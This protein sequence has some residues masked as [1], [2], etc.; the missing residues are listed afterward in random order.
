MGQIIGSAAKPKRCN[1]NKLSQFGTPAAGEHI[2]VSSDNSMNAAGQGNFDCYIVGN[3]R[4]AATALKL[5]SLVDDGVFDI[6]TYRA[7]GDVLAKYADIAAA[8]DGG[9]NIPEA[10]RKGGMS[11]KF[12]QSSD[13]KYVQYLLTKDEW[14]V[15][16]ADW[17]KMN[18]EDE[19]SK[20]GQEV[21]VLENVKLQYTLVDGYISSSGQISTAS[22]YY[23]EKTTEEIPVIFGNKYRFTISYGTLTAMWCAYCLYD[24]NHASLGRKVIINSTGDFSYADISIQNE[25]AAYIRFSWR[26][27]NNANV[28]VFVGDLNGI[29]NAVNSLHLD[30]DNLF[31]ANT[32]PLKNV[33]ID[34]SYYNNK[35][36]GVINNVSTYARTKIIQVN[37]TYVY[38]AGFMRDEC[39]CWNGETFLGVVSYNNEQEKKFTLLPNTTHIAF[40]IRKASQ[41]EGYEESGVI[42]NF[43]PFVPVERLEGR[44]KSLEEFTA[45]LSSRTLQDLTNGIIRVSD[46][47]ID[48][49]Y[50]NTSTGAYITSSVPTYACTSKIKVTKTYCYIDGFV[51]NGCLCYSETEFLGQVLYNNDTEKKFT[52]LDGTVYVAFNFRKSS[53]PEGYKDSGII[54]NLQPFVKDYDSEIAAINQQNILYGKKWC[55]CGDSFSAWSTEQDGNVYK[56]YH[57]FIKNRNNMTISNMAVSGRTMAYPNDHTFDNAFAKPSI[58]QAIPSDS[59]YITIMLGINDVSHILGESQDAESVDGDI[60]IGNIDSTDTGT[61]YGAWNVVLQ[62]IFENRP[63]AHVGVIITNGLGQNGPNG[64]YTETEMQVYTALQN[65]VKKWNVPYI[66]L[67]GGD[68]RTPMMQ[69]GIY[70]EGT[71]AALIAAKWDAF[72]ASPTS[73]YNGHTNVAGHLYESYCIENFL[74]SL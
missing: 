67:N 48:N 7:T 65:I 3:G 72:A 66:D 6:S 55:V 58:Y 32:F 46:V 23:N 71:P 68:S 40:S 18:L 44:I 5:K 22:D 17:Q 59:D 41:P 11:V 45:P 52:F 16:K 15:S 2:L 56:T 43:E 61:F 54:F 4:D 74:R 49:H 69:R 53:Q 13:N 1:L 70:P 24:S 42:Y 33:F 62:W 57:Y 31:F 21:S 60:T 39:L 35:T 30:K 26:S 12:V 20:L 47:F 73:P 8:L 29:Q 28:G 10:I 63:N 51:Q 14:S 36:G 64:T 9:N 37:C 50:Y 34:N 19:V 25:N 27:Y 38:I